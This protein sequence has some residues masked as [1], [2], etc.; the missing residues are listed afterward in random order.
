MAADEQRLAEAKELDA[1]YASATGQA[2]AYDRDLLALVVAALNLLE[3]RK[4]DFLDNSVKPYSDLAEALVQF[5]PWL[6]QE[7]ENDP[8]AMGWVDDKGRP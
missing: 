7:D 4:K 3:H 2:E 5:E 8:R 1:A 6:E